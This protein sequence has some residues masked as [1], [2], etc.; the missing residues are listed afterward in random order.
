MYVDALEDAKNGEIPK[1]RGKLQEQVIALTVENRDLTKRLER[2]MQDT[3]D[4]V[5]E[6]NKLKAEQ[7]KDVKYAQIGKYIAGNAPNLCR[8]ILREESPVKVFFSAV[9]DL[10]KPSVIGQVPRLQQIEAEANAEIANANNRCEE[11]NKIIRK[12]YEDNV[13]GRITDE[14]FDYLSKSYEDEQKE[15]QRKIQELKEIL[16]VVDNDNEKLAKFIRIVRQYIRKSKNLRQIF[17][18]VS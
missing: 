8:S 5:K 15:L 1:K 6:N 2:S 18:I 17:F 7:S 16:A 9:E 13:S 3:L 12:L 14:R 4:M 11:I 10:C